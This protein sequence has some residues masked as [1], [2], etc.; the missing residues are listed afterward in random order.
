MNEV[1]EWTIELPD[2]TSTVRITFERQGFGIAGYTPDCSKDVLEIFDGA[3]GARLDVICGVILPDPITTSSNVA[4]IVFTAGPAHGSGRKG[5]KLDYESIAAPTTQPPTT[6]PTTATTQPPTTRP[7]TATTQPPTTRPTTATTQPPTQAGCGGRLTTDSGSLQSPN[8][9]QTY[10]VDEECEWI[11]ELPDHTSTIEI[12]FDNE[13]E[14]GIA[15]V[16]SA[17]TK[18]VL[19]IYDGLGSNAATLALICG[20]EVPDPIPTSSNVARIVF[21][22]GPAHGPLRRGFKLHFKSVAAPTSAPMLI[23]QT[24]PECENFLTMQDN[25]IIKSPN[26]PVTYPVN[27]RC[28]W[29]ITVSDPSKVLDISFDDHFGIAGSTSQNCLKDRLEIYDG[30]ESNA[31]S[32][33]AYCEFAVPPTRRTSSNKAKITFTALGSHGPARVGFKATFTCV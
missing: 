31:A 18:D 22:A 33:G 30:H 5:F 25:Q 13:D 7:T 4:R 11:I 14:F 20:T 2:P 8:W 10:N 21:T 12:S 26:W 6:R 23:V 9:P 24:S 16:S 19:E 32:L 27:L 17:C 29:L 15:G 28:E 1:C 3:N